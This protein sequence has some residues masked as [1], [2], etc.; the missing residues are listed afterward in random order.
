MGKQVAVIGLGLFGTTIAREATAIGHDVLGIDKDARRVE[1][2][3]DQIAHAVRGDALEPEVLQRLGVSSCHTAIVAIGADQLSNIMVT[4]NLMNMGVKNVICR[5]GNEL[6][7]KIL[8]RL[9]VSHV[10]LPE[11][12]TGVRLAHTF[13]SPHVLQYL[14]L[15]PSHGVS[16]FQVPEAL[17]GK[18]LLDTG[19]SHKYG[20]QVLMVVRGNQVMVNPP[21]LTTRVQHGDTLVVVGGDE[22]VEK[23]RPG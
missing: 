20:L 4:M 23:V 16:K 15:T 11:R 10:A 22:A 7:A 6:H 21:G 17:V 5:A 19:L 13:A 18:S 12:E 2:L 9:G 1:E 3:K 8:E 14:E